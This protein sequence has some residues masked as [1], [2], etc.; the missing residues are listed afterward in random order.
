MA[1]STR[2]VLIVRHAQQSVGNDSRYLTSYHTFIL[3][4]VRRS[5][6]FSK[7]KKPTFSKAKTQINIARFDTLNNSHASFRNL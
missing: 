3:V 7:K 1:T 2:G 4:A 5:S 6:C